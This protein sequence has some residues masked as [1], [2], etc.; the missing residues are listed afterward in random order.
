MRSVCSATRVD[1]TVAVIVDPVANVVDSRMDVGVVVV[2]VILPVAGW[3]SVPIDIVEAERVL[4]VDD[5]HAA[6]AYLQESIQEGDTVLVKGS[7]GM[8]MEHIIEAL[9]RPPTDGGTCGNNGQGRR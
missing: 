9:A 6:I 3:K 7:R 5:N 1:Q 8:A 2:T 4:C